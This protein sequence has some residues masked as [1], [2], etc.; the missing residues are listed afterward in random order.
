MKLTQDWI[1]IIAQEAIH[2]FQS[3]ENKKDLP[4]IIL[5]VGKKHGFN[6]NYGEV[7]EIIESIF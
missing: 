7:N 5:I 1:D 2:D 3:V 4:E 6:L